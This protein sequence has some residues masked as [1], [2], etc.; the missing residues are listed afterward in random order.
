MTTKKQVAA[1]RLNATK[2]TGPKTAAGKL[3][4]SRNATTHGL[5]ATALVL[6][7]EDGAAFEALSRNIAKRYRVKGELE[8]AFARQV[9]VN[10][11]RCQ[12]VAV[13]EASL[14]DVLASDDV[15]DAEIGELQAQFPSE[16]TAADI[17][18]YI[19]KITRGKMVLR[20]ISGENVLKRLSRYEMHLSNRL[21]ESIER[22]DQVQK[23]GAKQKS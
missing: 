23:L 2:S 3:K 7:G 1:N 11:W 5:T 14:L 13:F 16:G 19:T 21:R 20:A 15:A 9:A 18:E 12:R 17:A 8:S 6:E 10:F 4:S 22:L